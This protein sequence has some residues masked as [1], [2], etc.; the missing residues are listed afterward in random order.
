M[1]KIIRI[2]LI[3]QHY[4]NLLVSLFSINKIEELISQK[5]YL[6]FINFY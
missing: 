5:Y 4:N 2:E 3:S 6:Q 1:L